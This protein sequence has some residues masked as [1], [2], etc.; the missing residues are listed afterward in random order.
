MTRVNSLGLV[1]IEMQPVG[2]RAAEQ[3]NTGSALPPVERPKR[4]QRMCCLGASAVL[5]LSAGIGLGFYALGWSAGS[6]HWMRAHESCISSPPSLPLPPLLPPGETRNDLAIKSCMALADTSVSL[7]RLVMTRTTNYPFETTS[8]YAAYKAHVTITALNGTQR[9]HRTGHYPNV[10]QVE[11]SNLTHA[12]QFQNVPGNRVAPFTD[13]D[14]VN[15]TVAGVLVYMH[16]A[17]PRTLPI[18]AVDF[19]SRASF[20]ANGNIPAD[21]LGHDTRDVAVLL[22]AMRHGRRHHSSSLA[23]TYQTCHVTPVGAG[24]VLVTTQGEGDYLRYRNHR[25]HM[26]T[27][28]DRNSTF[29]LW[30][31]W[32]DK[33]A[34]L[35]PMGR[36]D[37]AF[38]SGEP[39]VVRLESLVVNEV[40]GGITTT[41]LSL[42]GRVMEAGACVMHVDSQDGD[43]ASEATADIATHVADD[44]EKVIEAWLECAV[45]DEIGDEAGCAR[46]VAQVTMDGIDESIA[47]VDVVDDVMN[48]NVSEAAEFD[49]IR[50]SVDVA[51]DTVAETVGAVE[52][53]ETLDPFAFVG[54]I[55]GAVQEALDVDS[56]VEDSIGI[57][58]FEDYE[59]RYTRCYFDEPEQAAH[60]NVNRRLLVCDPLP[61]PGQCRSKNDEDG[62]CVRLIHY[63]TPPLFVYDYACLWNFVRMKDN[64]TNT[65]GDFD[66]WSVRDQ[67]IFA[68]ASSASPLDPDAINSDFSL[69]YI[70]DV[71][72]CRTNSYGK[73]KGTRYYTKQ[74]WMECG[75]LS[76]SFAGAASNVLKP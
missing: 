2:T 5:F 42:D 26:Y 40:T 46:N 27:Y 23:V 50:D 12:I 69:K 45:E 32:K 62:D 72:D 65:L 54:L 20:V 52:A 49:V 31:R 63:D 11:A 30:R 64:G 33:N 61:L 38:A 15:G 43:A 9:F 59:S 10:Y 76:P 48:P 7:R 41:A 34:M 70:P 17:M 3:Y 4:A 53:A 21:L 16:G 60:P 19:T 47:A 8:V 35:I 25:H 55:P 68:E 57:A 44:A 75:F 29:R 28:E 36:S 58:S 22:S 67:C 71:N 66:D 37:A 39:S 13:D 51:G 18:V 24:R 73:A 74:K 14:L 1:G 56:L 6:N